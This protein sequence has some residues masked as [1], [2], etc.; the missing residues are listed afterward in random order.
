[1]TYI[2]DIVLNFNT[3]YYEFFEWETKDNL[4]LVKKIPLIKVDTTFLDDVLNRKIKIDDPITLELFNKCEIISKKHVKTVKYMFL[5]TDS[6]R[7][8]GLTLN[9]ELIIDK[10]SSLP[11]DLEEEAIESAKRSNLRTITY[12]IIGKRNNSNFLTRKEM[13]IKN[14]LLEEFK[15]IEKR[16]DYLKLNYLYYEF[17]NHVPDTNNVYEKLVASLKDNLT[18][19]HL[20]LYNLLKFIHQ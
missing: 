12:T 11:L 15:N 8:L 16:K 18:K 7:V 19:D 13:K 1:M 6:Y 17:F 20:K 9:N 2:Y 4:T 14:Y 10:I 3:L 5:I